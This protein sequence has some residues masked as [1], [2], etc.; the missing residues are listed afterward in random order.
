MAD[1]SEIMSFLEVVNIAV[2]L[3]E[4]QDPEAKLY[5]VQAKLPADIH[6]STTNPL[7]LSQ[8]Q[9]VFRAGKGGT[10]FI[11]STG[12]GI[13]AQPQFN[14]STWGG[15]VVIPWPV[16]MEIVEAAMLLQKAGYTGPFWNC[17][18]RHPLGRG[19]KPYDEPYY[20]FGMADRTY[21]SVGVNDKEIYVN[22]AGEA[23]LPGL[24]GW[25]CE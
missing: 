7:A 25:T 14:S 10:W 13:W 3:I 2:N 19:G 9:A 18:L 1:S 5:E 6:T 21:V 20:I 24:V 11:N 16:K 8:L 17:T 22:K 23:L 4:A 12:W 15:D